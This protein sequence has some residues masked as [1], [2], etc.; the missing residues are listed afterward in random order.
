VGIVL[1]IVAAVVWIVLGAL[2]VTVTGQAPGGRGD[3]DLTFQVIHLLA[4]R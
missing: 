2:D 1:G 4:A 3:G